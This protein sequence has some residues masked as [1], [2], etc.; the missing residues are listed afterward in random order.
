MDRLPT[1][2]ART[3]AAVLVPRVKNN[4]SNFRAAYVGGLVA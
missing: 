3:E 4:F 1:T 2:T